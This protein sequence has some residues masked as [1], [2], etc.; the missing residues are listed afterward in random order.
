VRGIQNEAR[1]QRPSAC[2]C[3]RLADGVRKKRNP[4]RLSPH[5]KRKAALAGG[6]LKL[7]KFS[8]YTERCMDDMLALVKQAKMQSQTTKDTTESPDSQVSQTTRLTKHVHARHKQAVAETLELLRQH[9]PQGGGV[10]VRA[11]RRNGFPV[12]LVR[13]LISQAPDLKIFERM[14]RKV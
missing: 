3:S 1:K 10:S 4:R 2:E 11:L 7:S 14:V 5:R 6:L 9:L 12:S 8:S 13:Q